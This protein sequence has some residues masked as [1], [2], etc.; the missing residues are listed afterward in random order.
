MALTCKTL[1]QTCMIEIRRGDRVREKTGHREGKVIDFR[2]VPNSLTDTKLV[3]LLVVE[4]DE[5]GRICS[6]ANNW[7]PIA[8]QYYMEC[9]PSLLLD[10]GKEGE[11]AQE[12]S[13]HKLPVEI[14][15][16]IG[17]LELEG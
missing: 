12:A 16:S 9:Y 1:K 4:T 10:I 5:G 6:T 15:N 11:A 14:N 8:D 7:V 2:L 13:N 3:C 17:M